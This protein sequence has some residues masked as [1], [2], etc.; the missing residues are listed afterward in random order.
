EEVLDI[1]RAQQASGAL[2]AVCHS[3]RH[4]PGFNLVRQL[5]RAGR[6]GEI[7]TLDLIEQVSYWHFAHSYIRGNWG[8]SGRATPLL[9]AKSCHDLDYM[10]WLMDEPA[11]RVASFGSLS[12]FRPEHAP[13][14]APARCLE[15]CPVEHT[16][17][18]SAIRQYVQAD[19]TQWPASV[20]SHD[21]SQEAHLEALRTGPYGLCVYQADNDVVDHQTVML[22]HQN[23]ATATFTVTAFTQAGGRRLRVNGTE[24]DLT[25][26][27]HVVVLRDYASGRTEELRA[28]GDGPHGGGDVRVIRN[29][30]EAVRRADPAWLLTDLAASMPSHAV[31]FAAELARREGRL[32]RV[33]EVLG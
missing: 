24:A 29:W 13:E 15:A 19:R 16:C 2:A 10:A 33:D 26:D 14:G 18:Y 8:N 21:H 17:A 25:F 28:G 6:V 30:L 20:I 4:Q 9:L 23:G 3:L 31:G 22:E 11:V 12:H 27:E 5:V 1:Q 32:V 7:R